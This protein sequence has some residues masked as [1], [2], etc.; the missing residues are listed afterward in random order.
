MKKEPKPYCEKNEKK[1]EFMQKRRGLFRKALVAT[2][3]CFMF[4]LPLFAGCGTLSQGGSAASPAPS[5]PLGD[6]APKQPPSVLGLDPETDKTIFTTESGLE[7]KFGGANL[8]SG[9]LSGYAYF[10]MGSYNGYAVNWVIIARHSANKA[11][12]G[13]NITEQILRNFLNSSGE[14]SLS[15]YLETQTPAGSA[16]YND[17]HNGE[18]VFQEV[19]TFSDVPT[20]DTFLSA[21]E[22][23]CISECALFE[24]QFQTSS[25]ALPK[26]EGSNLQSVCQ[27]LPTT[28]GLTPSQTS[29][30]VEKNIVSRYSIISGQTAADITSSNQT[31][32]P[33]CVRNGRDYI[34]GILKT[35]SLRYACLIGTTT[36]T[37]YWLR[38][39]ETSTAMSIKVDGSPDD[40]YN[41]DN[42]VTSSLN[43]RP[44][45]VISVA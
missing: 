33:P 29:M 28:L 23:Y 20:L 9:P 17:A 39:G 24:A 6:I 1:P 2:L 41:W 16:I 32:Y 42:L 7:I 34:Q 31:F 12:F 27:N 3:A 25:S 22:V 18:F 14:T 38:D 37:E 45:C 44:C 40:S 36:A 19:L 35:G 26:Y 8:S 30:V 43:L 21:N 4:C 15:G 5:G 10:T 11:G 13:P